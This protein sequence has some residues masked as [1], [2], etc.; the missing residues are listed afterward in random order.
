MIQS[1]TTNGTEG[2][3]EVVNFARD[4]GDEE[5]DIDMDDG[6]ID[7]EAAA[8][9][10]ASI[11]KFRSFCGG[12]FLTIGGIVLAVAIAFATG[13]ASGSGAKQAELIQMKAEASYSVPTFGC[14][15]KKGGQ[16]TVYVNFA[17]EGTATQSSIYKEG[18]EGGEAG[19]AIDGN[20]DGVWD[21]GSVMHTGVYQP[22]EHWWMVDLGAEHTIT[23]V[24]VYNRYEYP[25]RINGMVVKVLD[26]SNTNV[27]VQTIV[28]EDPQYN[29]DFDGGIQGRYVRLERSQ[30]FNIAEVEVMGFS[31][32]FCKK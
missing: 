24:K 7:I 23:S 16:P 15:A 12:K 5:V 9:P 25:E 2:T 32:P 30:F 10:S 6:P 27:D 17:L 14:K 28:G 13:F 31:S 19:L 21:N 22:G 3:V 1:N 8:A 11:F 26:K 4:S 29:F 20:T 18:A